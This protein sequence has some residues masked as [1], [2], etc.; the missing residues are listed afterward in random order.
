MLF[1]P[2]SFPETD[3]SGFLKSLPFE[4]D[5][6]TPGKTVISSGLCDLQ[7]NGFAGTDYN[8]PNITPEEFEYSLQQ[9]LSN[10]VTTCLPTIITGS[11]EYQIRC[12]RKLEQ[13]RKC[14]SIAEAMVKGY[15]LE[16]PYLNPAEGFRGC[17]PHQFMVP[18][19][20]DHFQKL[21]DSAGGMIR[22]ITVAPEIE[23]VIDMIP[24]WR[25]QGITVSLGHCNPSY[26]D[27]QKA[28]DA[29]ARMSTHLGNGC[30]QYIPRLKNPILYQLS[31][32]RLHASFIADGAHLN[33]HALKVFLKAKED[34]RT[35]LVSDATAGSCA[36]P[37]KYTLGDIILERQQEDIVYIP[38]TKNLAGSASSLSQCVINILDWFKV[39]LEKVIRWSS[40]HPKSIIGLSETP[41]VGERIEWIEW[42]KMNKTWKIHKVRFGEWEIIP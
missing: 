6:D 28:V 1:K 3:Q 24:R 17:H 38:G 40:E 34:P 11:Q 13:V 27:I 36:E 14:S 8:D 16:G 5:S 30:A 37:G 22:L 31:E 33:E 10:G 42:E 35:I 18:P 4:E 9:L 21:Q 7:I 25:E 12:F 2:E 19:S 32:D 23:G 15:H 20:W 29:G 26:K 39:P 41:R